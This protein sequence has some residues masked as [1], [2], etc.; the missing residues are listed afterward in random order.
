MIGG[1]G[2]R[3]EGEKE[4]RK[5]DKKKCRNRKGVMN[6]GRSQAGKKEGVL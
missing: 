3:E 4:G 6:E 5:K 2:G 1:M